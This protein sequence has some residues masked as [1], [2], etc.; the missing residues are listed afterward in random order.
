LFFLSTYPY[1]AYEGATLR[2]AGELTLYFTQ[3]TV[4]VIGRHLEPLAALVG[5][6]GV[7]SIR[8][9]HTSPFAILEGAPYIERIDI[10]PP[11]VAALGK[12]P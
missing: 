8:A 2:G 11:N 4:T 7:S 6:E 10:G 12:K 5:N 3:G 9:Q 1:S